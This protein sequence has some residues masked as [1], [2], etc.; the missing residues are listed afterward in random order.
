LEYPKVAY[1][2]FSSGFEDPR[3]AYYLYYS[4]G[5]K[6]EDIKKN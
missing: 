6:P 3:E 5:L 4:K 1:E 2:Y